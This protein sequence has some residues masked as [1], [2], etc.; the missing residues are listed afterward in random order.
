MI[1]LPVKSN[2]D[3]NPWRCIVKEEQSDNPE[4][5]EMLPEVF[6]KLHK[7]IINYVLY[8]VQPPDTLP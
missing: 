7:R 8:I 5:S 3:C 2:G 4:M 6:D 1:D